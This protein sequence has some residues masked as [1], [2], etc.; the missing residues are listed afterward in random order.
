[1]EVKFE[2]KIIPLGESLA[3]TIP[4]D[5]VKQ[6][7]ITTTDKAVITLEENYIKIIFVR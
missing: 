6:F 7:N 5:I 4:I 1:M 2:R 3:V